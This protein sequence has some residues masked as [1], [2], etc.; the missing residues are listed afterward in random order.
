MASD[1]CCGGGNIIIPQVHRDWFGWGWPEYLTSTD[2][3]PTDKEIPG[4]TNEYEKQL[5]RIYTWLFFFGKSESCLG[6]P[7]W[8]TCD[9]TNQ[10][11]MRH[12]LSEIKD[13]GALKWVLSR[14]CFQGILQS[15]ILYV[16]KSDL[17]KNIDI[18]ERLFFYKFRAILHETYDNA[19]KDQKEK[20]E[21]LIDY[22]ENYKL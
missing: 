22:A 19:A 5:V 14:R 4:P 10:R 18:R 7:T 8:A 17:R 20:F 2:T 12:A 16:A 11:I 3:Y 21:F 9:G 13:S 1:G 6:L 15:A